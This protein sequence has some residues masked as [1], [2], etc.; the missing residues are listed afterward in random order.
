[1]MSEIL[2]GAG[3]PDNKANAAALAGNPNPNAAV[4]GHSV[5]QPVMR[6]LSALV[7]GNYET[8]KQFNEAL[9][10]ALGL[11]GPVT[12]DQVK[13]LLENKE[14]GEQFA[15]VVKSLGPGAVFNLMDSYSKLPD[16]LW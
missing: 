3:A 14:M 9:E 12:P 11:N 2:F 6:V 4:G 10:K 8:K 15:E 5:P 13:K 16:G 1:M 7:G